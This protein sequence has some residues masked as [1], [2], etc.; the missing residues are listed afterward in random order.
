[1]RRYMTTSRLKRLALLASDF[2]V[3]S[4]ARLRK[5]FPRTT[6]Q[7]SEV[8]SILVVALGHLGDAL[9]FSYMLPP[10]RDRFPKAAIDVLTG[11]YCAP[12]FRNNEYVRRVIGFDHF[13][14]NRSRISFASK[15]ALHISTL[16][17]SV[18]QIREARYDLS[19]DPKLHYPNGN[20][21]TYLGNI[22]RRI[23]FG[24][25]GFGSL[26]TE[27]FELPAKP[28][29]HYSEIMAMCLKASGVN[30]SAR[31]LPYFRSQNRLPD[32][33]KQDMGGGCFTLILPESGAPARMLSWDF[34]TRIVEQL[35]RR[36]SCRILIA[37]VDRT[38]SMWAT[39]F[40]EE[41]PSARDRV[42]DIVGKLKLTDIYELGR[43]A[44]VSI[45]V[46]SLP[47]HLCAVAGDTISL[48]KNGSGSLYFPIGGKTVT[49]FH[50]HADSRSLT[51]PAPGCHCA[52]FPSIES[53]DVLQALDNRILELAASDKIS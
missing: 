53:D 34:W 41:N 40:L 6:S 3:G 21:V 48:F 14:L 28:A 38:T 7:R 5:G 23:G 47:A 8:Q 44:M 32:S 20:L 51:Q 10:L 37:G 45:T 2:L 24:S 42:V 46:E 16:W 4:Y 49:V 31:L 27:E 35:L 1:M 33:L 26:L 15:V 52:F 17:R 22:N 25:G 39:Q 36:A 43:L 30:S 13:R 11:T 18:A 29:F 9:L 19:L 50:D 12:I